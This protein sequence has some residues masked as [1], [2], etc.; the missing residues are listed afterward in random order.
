MERAAAFGGI[1]ERRAYGGRK[2]QRPWWGLKRANTHG[3]IS[4]NRR[5]FAVILL[6]LS[7]P[8]LLLPSGFNPVDNGILHRRTIRYNDFALKPSLYVYDS[9]GYLGADR[10]NTAKHPAVGSVPDDAKTSTFLAEMG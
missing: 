10:L 9:G 3:L 7:L 1:R 5:S 6:G 8:L 2:A 4:L